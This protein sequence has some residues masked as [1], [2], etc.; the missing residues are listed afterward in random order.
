VKILLLAPQ[1]FYQVRGTPIAIDLLASTLSTQG[2]E[3][4]L[5]TYH[6]GDSREYHHVNHIRIRAFKF[7]N[8]VQ[9]G[10]SA[11]KLMCSCVLFFTAFRLLRKEN[12]DLIHANEE[13]VFMAYVFKKLFKKPYV[14]DMDSSMAAQ[15]VDKMPFLKH[16][17]GLFSWF[18]NL[19][20]RNSVGVLAV[21]EALCDIA[22][23]HNINV[24]LLTDVAML[25]QLT[26]SDEVVNLAK[27]YQLASTKIMYIGNLESYQGID[28]LIEGFAM[29]IKQQADPENPDISL[30]VIGG[31][32]E[33][34]SAYR[35]KCE[36]LGVTNSVV[37]AGPKPF[38]DLE[39]YMDQVDILVSPRTQGENTPM[40]I[41]NYMAS[42]KPMIATD[43]V[44]HTQ[45]LD[46]S[47][48]QLVAVEP[49]AFAAAINTL[50]VS[51]EIRNEMGQ[52]CKLHAE[53]NYS[54][55][56]FEKRLAEFYG[57]L[58]S[59]LKPSQVITN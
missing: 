5:L 35:E 2:H 32:P 53:K 33:T 34:I 16:L 49:A 9:P 4:D 21:C 44:S 22:R 31:T 6:E 12:Y 28:L 41:Y 17:R 43:I 47:I 54:V 23:P 18:E 11:K 3:I 15:L 37:F 56:S 50:A 27:Q 36:Q 25:D 10:F 39:A 51:P 29:A 30:I 13:A 7:L 19:A 48:A 46:A 8:G 38:S 40:K 1:P 58:E 14:Y 42:G 52:R 57:K 26:P 45:V 59:Q 20:I 24:E 55:A